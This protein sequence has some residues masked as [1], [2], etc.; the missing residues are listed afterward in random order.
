MINRTKDVLSNFSKGIIK[1]NNNYG[2]SLLETLI[3]VGL[4]VFIISINLD[5]FS[6]IKSKN[7]LKKTVSSSEKFLNE[8]KVMTISSFEDSNY[9]VHFDEDRMVLFKGNIFNSEDSENKEIFFDTGVF[10]TL[11]LEGGGSDVIFKKLTGE[12]DYYGTITF[13]LAEGSFEETLNILSTG[14][15]YLGE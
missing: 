5:S 11:N 8:A 3:V 2:F 1:S 10:C 6:N 7:L 15:I 9:G 13:S 12:T 4:M 14:I